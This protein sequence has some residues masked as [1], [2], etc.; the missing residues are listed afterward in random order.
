VVPGPLILASASPQRRAILEQLGIAFTVTPSGAAE[1]EQGDPEGLARENA[2]RKARAV[3]ARLGSGAAVL[4][5]DTDVAL[6]G[7]ILG[8]PADAAEATAMLGRLQGRAHEVWS[9]IVLIAGG[10]EHVETVRTEVRFAPAGAPEIDGYVASGEWEGR[11]G[12]YA[13][14]GRGAWLVEGVE[15]DYFNV[16]GLPVAALRRLLSAVSTST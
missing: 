9:G 16:V 14:Q 1:L 6:D 4:G 12:G 10:A 2:L 11:A 3:A 15:G 8:K 7:E 13:I 5:V